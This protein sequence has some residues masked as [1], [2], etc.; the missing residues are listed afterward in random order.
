M[1]KGNGIMYV[2]GINKYN[3]I[4]FE[5]N[6]HNSVGTNIVCPPI[7][8]SLQTSNCLSYSTFGSHSVTIM[9]N[10]QQL[11]HSL[12]ILGFKLIK[13][14]LQNGQESQLKMNLVMNTNLL[15]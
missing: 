5:S 8:I 14:G 6:N 2:A 15:R 11:G 12:A 4:Y 7:S 13:K 9:N 3:Q 10:L 1:M